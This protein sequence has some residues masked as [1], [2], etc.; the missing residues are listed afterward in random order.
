VKVVRALD[1]PIPFLLFV[2]LGVFGMSALLKWGFD[3]AGLY[4]AKAVLPN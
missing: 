1:H 4:G 3:T 2:T